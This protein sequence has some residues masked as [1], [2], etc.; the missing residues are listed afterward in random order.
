MT[1]K[2]ISELIAPCGMNCR[3]CY[4]YQREKKQCKGCRNE[5]D[6]KYKT[7]GCISCIIKNCPVLQ[8]SKTNYCFQCEQF[9]CKILKQLDKRYRL[10]YHMSMIE[11]LEVIKKDGIKSFLNDQ[12]KKWICPECGSILCAHRNICQVCKTIIFE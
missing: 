7:K 2:M 9:P 5:I 10:K 4:A 12:E 8:N 1:N 11:N 3:L 6:I